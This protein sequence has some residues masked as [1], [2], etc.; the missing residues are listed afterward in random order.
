MPAVTQSDAPA[1][2]PTD[3]PT[4]TPTDSQSDE[5]TDAAPRAASAVVVLVHGA[6]HGAWCWA[7]LQAELDC[8]GVA[9]L[10]VDLP[11]HGASTEALGDLHGDAASLAAVLDQLAERQLGPVV[12]VGHSYGGAV[13]THAAAGRSDIAHLI[14]VAAFAL[15][16]GE[17]VVGA[18]RDLERHDVE[19]RDVERR[20]VELAGAM[21]PTADGS[22]T[23][24]DRTRAAGAL[25]NECPPEAIAAALPRLTP[26]PVATLTQ[27]VS[28]APRDQVESTYVACSRDHAVHP[29]HQDAFAERCAHRVVLDT[30]HS[31]FISAVSDLAAVIA[32]VAEAIGKDER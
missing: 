21:I 27:P 25:Y 20:D 11:G 7:P 26:Q 28:G 12:L 30:D 2:T 18:L 22:A 3:L 31:P 17:S 16:D 24:L 15:D 4:D 5:R 1:D 23:V 8:A 14:Y 6:W 32:S 13:I 19:R 9:S 10:A 29:A